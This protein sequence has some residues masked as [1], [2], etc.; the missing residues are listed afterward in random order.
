MLYK[1]PKP[2][3]K[4]IYYEFKKEAKDVPFFLLKKKVHRYILGV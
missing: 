3:K 2:R 1:K 4:Q